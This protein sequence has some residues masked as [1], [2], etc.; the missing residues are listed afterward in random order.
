MSELKEYKCPACGGAMEFDSK[1]QKMKCP[2]CDTEIEI[3]EFDVEPPEPSGEKEEPENAQWEEGETD[4]IKIFSCDSCGGEILA[5]DTSGAV[6]C[7]FCGSKIVVKSQF[8]DDLK[9]DYVIPF[10]LDK[11]KAKEAYHKHLEKKPF[12]PKIF[13]AE[14]HIDE[15][16]G[17]YVPF[18][19]YDIDADADI[20]YEAEKLRI[21][22]VGNT[23][24]TE[25]KFYEAIRRGTIAFEHIPEDGSEKMDDSLM[26]SV[27]PFDFKDAVPFNSA[28]L[29]G[30]VADRY[31]VS[32]EDRRKR[33]GERVKE[34]AENTFRE[35]V[36]GYN[37]VRTRSSNVTTEKSRYWYALYPVW[38]LNTTWHGKKYVFAMNGQTGKLVGDLP[39]D[40][41]LFWKYVGIR[42]PL[43]AA[44]ATALL[45]LIGMF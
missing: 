7:P 8:A 5:E 24:F 19:L 29:A 28:Y 25:H 1:S 6:I 31:D 41:S 32:V 42:T 17:V 13:R 34:S 38:I 9:P 30:Y 18:W 43:F 40:K 23:E 22:R 3:K 45:F 37:V 35:T 11:K 44:I 14:N 12:L 10:K 26:E 15:I 16:K 36:T 20:V 27:E 4:K 2:Y 39:V 21:W 33:A